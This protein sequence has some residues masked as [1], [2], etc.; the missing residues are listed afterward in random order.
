[1]AKAVDI[2]GLAERDS[3]KLDQALA[4]WTEARDKLERS[5]AGDSS[6][7]TLFRRT[8]A[9]RFDFEI[10]TIHQARGKMQAAFVSFTAAKDRFTKLR[11]QAPKE[12]TVLLGSADTHDKL[13]DVLRND[14]KLDLALDEYV[15][16][17]TERELAG[18]GG[19]ARPPEDIIA[20]STSHMKLG[21]V[22]LARGE[23]AGALESFKAALRLRET[24]LETEP[25]NVEIVK[26]VLAVQ[27]ELADVQRQLGDDKGA[28]QTYREMMPMSETLAH[29]DPTNTAWHRD[30]GNLISNLGFALLDVGE[31]DE[32]IKD[33]ELGIETQ[34]ALVAKDEKALAWQGD[35][36]RSYLRT[37]DGY[38]Y[39]NDLDKAIGYY[40]RSLEIRERLSAAD[41]KSA[42]FH[43][44]VAWAHTKL[45]NAYAEQQKFDAAITAH[46]KALALRKKLVD[47][48][49]AHTG[50]KN[51]LASTEVTLGEL[52]APRDQKRAKELI[53]SGVKH[54]RDLVENDAVNVEWKETLTQALIAQA[55]LAKATGDRT[56][57]VAALDEARVL[58]EA[59]VAGAPQNAHWPGYVAEIHAGLAEAA[60]DAKA[61]AAEWKIVRDTLE[62][63]AQA[64]RLPAY[65]T[66]LLERAR[67]Q[68]GA[69]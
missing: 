62:P 24:L 4:T 29:R 48:S 66:K 30:R 45:G 69:R 36:S 49:P 27:N 8:M 59:A 32:G 10:G 46:D 38:V 35:L 11:E 55:T 40:E 67:A 23:S 53:D 68:V 28:I 25:D 34:K 15:E 51:E 58:A 17:K 33:L 44:A 54:A 52:L 3:G 31:F 21:S 63:L 6:T 37:G 60:P 47:E 22:Y 61:A 2:V 19:A 65:R 64:K 1:M 14:G 7:A 12:R 20:L 43:R 18:S 50:F 16:A 5:I 13:G 39:T 56:A 42:P 57:R 9:A 26:E 41:P